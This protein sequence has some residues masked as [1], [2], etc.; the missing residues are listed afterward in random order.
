M[1]RVLLGSVALLGLSA[2]VPVVAADM[3]AAP[4]VVKSA[5]IAAATWTGCYIGANIGYGRARN[6]YTQVGVGNDG[7]H[8]AD[9]LVAGG[10]IGCD[11]EFSNRWVVGV[12]GLFDWTDMDGQHVALLG[13]P[14]NT[15]TS[16]ISWI[17]TLTGRIGYALA[18]NLLPYIKGGAAWVRSE[19]DRIDPIA[20]LLGSAKV[21]HQGWTVGGG[22][23][24]MYRPDWT[25]FVEYN[26]MDTGSKRVNLGVLT[27]IDQRVQTVLVG[28]NYRFGTR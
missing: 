24:W 13:A 23:E 14:A 17:A 9:G 7:F 27:D 1:S 4:R 18:P 25:L 15:L 22:F 2:T 20:G 11:Y 21:T 12:Q 8:T 16:D 6:G 3:P 28:I 5:P 26:Y 10:Q 19:H